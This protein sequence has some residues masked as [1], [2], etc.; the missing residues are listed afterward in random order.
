MMYAMSSTAGTG[1]VVSFCALT[2]G[3]SISITGTPEALR[4]G[5]SSAVVTATIGAA[6]PN[7]KSTRE[8]G[9][10]GS[11]GRYAAPVLS[12]ARMAAIASPVRGS[13]SATRSPGRA[14][15]VTKWFAK[16]FAVASNSP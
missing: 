10:A 15:W 11:I 4:R 14:P 13:S 5:S 1:N 3:S 12:T 8:S 6:S 9:W 2:A 7:T 16:R